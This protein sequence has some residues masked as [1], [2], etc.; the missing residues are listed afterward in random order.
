MSIVLPNVRQHLGASPIS[1]GTAEL[2]AVRKFIA[3]VERDT[4]GYDSAVR[5]AAEWLSHQTSEAVDRLRVRLQETLSA[6]AQRVVATANDA[7]TGLAS[8]ADEISVIHREARAVMIDTEMAFSSIRTAEAKLSEIADEIGR[9]GAVPRYWNEVPTPFPPPLLDS[10]GDAMDTAAR[11]A[12]ISHIRNMYEYSWTAATNEWKQA[13]EVALN[14]PQ[15]WGALWERR[16]SSEDKLRSSLRDTPVGH[17]SVLSGNSSSVGAK[18]TIALGLTG[19][20]RGVKSEGANFEIQ[21]HLFENLFGTRVPDDWWESPPAPE[22]VAGWWSSLEPAQRELLIGE[23]SLLIGNLP[24]LPFDVRD[25]ANRETLRRIAANPAGISSD[26]ARLL[27][28]IQLAVDRENNVEIGDVDRQV[29]SLNIYADTVCASLSY[30][31]LDQVERIT[32]LAAG[33]E[34]DAAAAIRTWDDASQNVHTVQSRIL[35]A[36]GKHAVV[37]WLGYDTPKLA[38]VATSKGVLSSSKAE[39]GSVRFAAELDGAFESRKAFTAGLPV[40]NVGAHS[41]GVNTAAI[42]LTRTT[43]PVDSFTSFG[44]AGVDTS[45]VPEIRALNVKDRAPGQPAVFA[46]HANDDLLASTGAMLSGRKTFDDHAQRVIGS[47]GPRSMPG[48]L[49][50]SAEGDNK[51]GFTETDGH[52]VIGEAGATRI[53]GSS[54]TVGHGYLD[55][56]TQSLESFALITSRPI[57]TD[58]FDGFSESIGKR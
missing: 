9:V 10:R 32:W 27:S 31:D 30:G 36:A 55:L 24:G 56:G 46:V 14:A 1:G 39:R 11:E 4:S 48:V 43:Y 42:A 20:I 16:R 53:A 26:V 21:H 22:H 6:G 8:Y 40:M 29:V 41:Y 51:Q 33:M 19:E 52:S 3:D 38:D 12:M 45:F 35:G 47:A 18:R 57:G 54:A 25:Q 15:K 34:S 17:L 23:S 49:I 58:T 5:S 50:F 44:S 13:I 2:E 37:L 7:K 28:G